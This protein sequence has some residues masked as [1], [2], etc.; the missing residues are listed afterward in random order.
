MLFHALASYISSTNL[1]KFGVI[2]TYLCSVFILCVDDFQ[3]AAHILL[4]LH[5]TISLAGQFFGKPL[6]TTKQGS[7]LLERADLA[8]ATT[9]VS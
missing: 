8:S 6:Y 3:A 2:Q 1:S 7:Y 4:Y 9:V 5:A